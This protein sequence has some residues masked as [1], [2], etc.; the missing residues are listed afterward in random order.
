VREKLKKDE[1]ENRE[2]RVNKQ[3]VSSNEDIIGDAF[4]TKHKILD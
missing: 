1:D 2:G 4:W 3:I